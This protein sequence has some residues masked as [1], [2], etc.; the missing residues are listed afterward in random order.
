[1]ALEFKNKSDSEISV[2]KILVCGATGF[3]GRNLTEHFTKIG[4][5]KVYGTY[6][7]RP[8]YGVAGVEWIKAD[9][10]NAIEVDN[11]VKGM[12]IIIQ[13]AATTSGSRDIVNA[14]YL[15]VT[16]NAVMNS[17]ILRAAYDNRVGHVVFFSCTV[18]Y[19]SSKALLKETDFDAGENLVPQYFGVGWTK[20]Y[21]EKLCE[22]YSCI[23]E[24]KHT[25]IRHSNVYGEHDKYDL[26]R[27]HVFGA[28]ITKALSAKNGKITVWGEG[29][30]ARDLLYIG[31]LVD[32]VDLAI[33]K[34]SSSFGLYN[35]GCGAAIAVREL[36]DRVIGISGRS[37]VIEHD[38]SKPSIKTSL[39]LDCSKALKELGWRPQTTLNDGIKISIDWWNNNVASSIP[40]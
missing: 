10:T 19:Q 24:T 33:R 22:F 37:L 35:C 18:M 6:H 25:V 17:L 27:S 20:V 34:Q 2:L 28:T 31:D 15:H 8:H 7:T 40:V 30:E 36:V 38:L 26:E 39:A 1:M 29:S 4:K 5:Y 11:A 9:L 12:D 16:D 23:G 32:F 21:V 14:P 13:A 3:I